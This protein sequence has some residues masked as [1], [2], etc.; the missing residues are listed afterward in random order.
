M[1]EKF[2]LYI[3]LLGFSDIA[4]QPGRVEELYDV[5]DRLHVHGD[6]AFG[7]IA[8]S[9][10]I[11]VYN[12]INPGSAEV[13]Q[14]TVMFLCEFA[15][16]LFY[17]LIGKDTYFRAYL[18]YGSFEHKHLKHIES[19]Y[20]P[21]L[22]RAHRRASAIQYIGLFLDNAL[23]PYCDIFTTRRLDNECHYVSLMQTLDGDEFKHTTLPVPAS[24]L[25]DTDMHYLLSY[26]ITFLKNVHSHMTDTRFSPRIRRKYS[27]TWRIIRQLYPTFCKALEAGNFHPRAISDFDWSDVM[28]RVGTS[29]G[30]HG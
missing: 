26:D 6:D 5:M 10:T 8:F 22:I 20:G 2:L 13:V 17:R 14:M 9:D 3:D 28:A 27:N 19:F 1:D 15:K 25:V 30:F 18:T 23:V 4:D 11:L 21:A 7:V 29:R 24:W 16:D 12:K